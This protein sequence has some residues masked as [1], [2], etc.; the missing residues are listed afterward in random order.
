MRRFIGTGLRGIGFTFF[1]LTSVMVAAYAFAFLKVLPYEPQNPFM[2]SFAVQGLVVPM[3]FFGAGLALLLAPVQASAWVRRRWPALHRT[4]GWLYAGGVLA[5]GV[6]GLGMAFHAQGGWA[7]GAGFLL[8]AVTWLLVT[9]NGI[10]F[11]VLGDIARHRHWMVH[12]LAMTFGAVTLRVILF[13]GTLVFKLPLEPVYIFAAW[14]SW[15]FNMA[16]CEL[17]LRW[18]RRAMPLQASRRAQPA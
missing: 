17:W 1:A 9:G 2:A 3:H 13:G 12:S 4:S 18:R 6:A 15:T 5:G 10:R 8:L 11:A 14:T 7:S 16:V